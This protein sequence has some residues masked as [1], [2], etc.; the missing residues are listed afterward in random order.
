MKI[1][2]NTFT[3]IILYS[4]V[5]VLKLIKVRIFTAIYRQLLVAG[6][7]VGSC[8]LKVSKTAIVSYSGVPILTISMSS[9]SSSPHS[10]TS[11]GSSSISSS[12]PVFLSAPCNITS[13]TP[14]YIFSGAGS[15]G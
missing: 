10:N 7:T 8:I 9:R 5:T 13:I 12:L 15:P 2:T 3:F 1:I 6:L 4:L 14:G 11:D